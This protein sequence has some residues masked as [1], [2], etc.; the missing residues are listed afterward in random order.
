M[1]TSAASPSLTSAAPA[2]SAGNPFATR[3]LIVGVIGL[4]IALLGLFVGGRAT[5]PARPFFGYLIGFAFWLSMFIGM[6]MLVIM[7]YL[8]DAGWPI[9]IRRQLEHALAV[10]PWLALCFVPLLLLALGLFPGH[11][12]GL[13]WQWLDPSQPLIG[14]PGKTIGQDPLFIHKAAFLSLPFFLL[15]LVI[16][17]TVFWGLSHAFRKNSFAMDRDPRPEY[18]LRC[19]KFAALGVYC[20]ALS[21]T[22]AAF[23]LFMS[24]AYTWFSTMYGVWFFAASMRC[25]ISGTILM[26][27]FMSAKPGQPLFGIYNR[28]HQYL[29]GCLALTFT[30]FWAYVSFC[31]YFL[32]YN[33]DIPEET[34]WYNVRELSANWTQNSWWW[35]SLALIFCHFFVA[36][37]FL[38]NYHVKV[39]RR[40]LPGV[41]AWVLS[42][43]LLD[44]YF[45][46]LPGK[47]KIPDGSPDNVLHYTVR[48]FRP[49]IWDLASLVGIGG[50]CI[51]AYLR[52]QSK[53]EAIPIHD[54]RIDESLNYH[55]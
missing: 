15:R 42:F 41:A 36:F 17:L 53:A 21:L 25:G 26:C 20:V 46:I 48:E 24:L 34:F 52:S 23:D 43:H 22:F 18:V 30:V 2:S 37:F 51:W 39:A 6:L 47:L 3:A 44:L 14:E 45:N 28:A 32:I 10:I 16:Y 12:H 7:F 38:L 40:I 8:F 9:V 29:L 13:L 55:E 31:Q 4:A 50:I 27:F 19:R 5:D 49:E 54:P 11:A 33:A 1:N 35:V